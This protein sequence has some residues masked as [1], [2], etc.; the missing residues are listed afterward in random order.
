VEGELCAKLRKVYRAVMLE[1]ANL[2]VY[3]GDTLGQKL[4]ST[5]VSS[6]A[7]MSVN[8]GTYL[9]TFLFRQ[10]YLSYFALVFLCGPCRPCTLRYIRSCELSVLE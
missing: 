6:S 2:L 10:S 8:I 5:A 1:S 9:K 3:F 4:L 7:S